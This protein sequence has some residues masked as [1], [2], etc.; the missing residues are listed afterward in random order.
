MLEIVE[1]HSKLIPNEFVHKCEDFYSLLS[2]Y[3]NREDFIKEMRNI[4]Q[5]PQQRANFFQILSE[6]NV[7][8]DTQIKIMRHPFARQLSWLVIPQKLFSTHKTQMPKIQYNHES[9]YKF[10]ENFLEIRGNPANETDFLNIIQEHNLMDD[11]DFASFCNSINWVGE[12]CPKKVLQE[13]GVPATI[14]VTTKQI[15]SSYTKVDYPIG[16]PERSGQEK[17]HFELCN[18]DWIACEYQSDDSRRHTVLIPQVNEALEDIED[19]HTYIDIEIVRNMNTLMYFLTKG[20]KCAGFSSPMI[21]NEMTEIYG[22]GGPMILELYKRNPAKYQDMIIKRL[23]ARAIELRVA[24][25]QKLEQFATDL[26]KVLPTQRSKYKSAQLIKNAF[27]DFSKIGKHPIIFCPEQI[28]LIAQLIEKYIEL[29][30]PDSLP[31]NQENEKYRRNANMIMTQLHDTPSKFLVT[32]FNHAITLCSAAL[33]TKELS[34]VKEIDERT[35]SGVKVAV[36]IG[37]TSEDLH[38]HWR[39]LRIIADTIYKRKWTEGA[40]EMSGMFFEIN[41]TKAIHI[42]RTANIFIKA[43]QQFSIEEYEFDPKLIA[44]SITNNNIILK[45]AENVNINAYLD[46]SRLEA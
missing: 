43:I 42:I 9:F 32:T 38:G 3:I 18:M 4:I 27:P 6:K 20:K 25:I 19:R 1:K 44:Y 24:K 41:L 37:I 22:K 15:L 30:N 12:L 45:S 46:L 2:K 40:R 33:L 7:P 29:S 11:H 36:E 14:G 39:L 26:E 35:R 17:R 28:P 10:I 16:Y 21:L 13:I 34:V 8:L 5:N 23:R 31:M